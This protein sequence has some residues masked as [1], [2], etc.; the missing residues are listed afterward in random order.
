GEGAEGHDE[1]AAPSVEEVLLADYFEEVADN[2]GDQAELARLS[3]TATLV[4]ELPHFMPQESCLLSALPFEN[5]AEAT[6]LCHSRYFPLRRGRVVF[7][8]QELQ[9]LSSTDGMLNDLC[10]N[11][12]AALL[13]QKFSDPAHPF[14]SSA[15]RCAVFSSYDLPLMRHRASTEEI[16]RR[17]R[18]TEYWSRDVWILPIHHSATQHWVMCTVFPHRGEIY[19]FDSLAARESWPQQVQLTRTAS[20]FNWPPVVGSLGLQ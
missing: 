11:G 19:I 6:S 12:I 9:I 8:P 10:I 17:T 4:W 7:G 16:W 20:K 1:D 14:S 15:R 18:H 3:V 2:D 13:A 5:P